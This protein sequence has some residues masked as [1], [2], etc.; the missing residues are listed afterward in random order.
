MKRRKLTLWFYEPHDMAQLREGNHSIHYG[1]VWD[2]HPGCHGPVKIMKDG[3]EIDLEKEWD[4][5]DPMVLAELVA[6]KIDADIEVKYRKTPFP[7]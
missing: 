5:S 3:T 7:D 4:S 1:N 2:F 6:K